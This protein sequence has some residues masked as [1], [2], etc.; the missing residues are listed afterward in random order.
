MDGAAHPAAAAPPGASPGPAFAGRGVTL[1]VVVTSLVD[2]R[3]AAAGGATRLEVA[4]QLSDDGLTPPLALVRQIRDEISL[5]LRVMLR[6]SPSWAPRHAQEIEQLA[7]TAEALARLGVDGLV[8]GFLREGRVDV[9][10]LCRLLGSAPLL[11]ATFHRAFDAVTYPAEALTALKT[12]EQ[13]DLVLTAGGGGEWAARLENWR[14]WPILARPEMTIVA[15]GGLDVAAIAE[16]RARTE[17]RQFHVGRAARP[18]G[19][20]SPVSVERV[21]ELRAAAG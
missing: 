18:A 1:E 16:L 17:L 5:P 3:A 19:W 2:A 13:V 12:C 9:G 21:R 7:A 11:A 6:Q 15:A 14:R 20:D 8:L 10:L 4:V